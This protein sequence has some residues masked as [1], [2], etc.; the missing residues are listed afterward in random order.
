MQKEVK[1]NISWV[2]ARRIATL[3]FL[4]T[5]MMSIV[6]LIISHI[7]NNINVALISLML[8]F[9]GSIIFAFEKIKY[10]I[11]LLLF[12]ICFFTFL[13]GRIFLLSYEKSNW[14][15]PF[16]ESVMQKS[17]N[18]M[19]IALIFIVIGFIF[20]EI[21]KFRRLKNQTKCI[22][23]LISLQN[24]KQIELFRLVSQIVM[25]ISFVPSFSFLVSTLLYSRRFG[26]ISLYT[27]YVPSAFGNKILVIYMLSFYLFLATMPSKNKVILYS[28]PYFITT[29]VSLLTGDRGTFVTS[30]FILAYYY[31][32][33]HFANKQ[34]FENDE[35]KWINGKIVII[36]VIV[37]PVLLA[38]LIIWGA[39]RADSGI[40]LGEY[41]SFD[42][43]VSIFKEFFKEQG[44]SS[45]IIS[46]A[47]IHIE[48][49]P[50]TNV[51]YSFGRLIE[52]VKHNKITSIVYTSPNPINNRIDYALYA[53]DFAHT[54]SY[55]VKP[56]NYSNGY[57][58]GSSYI[59]ELFVD[60]GL[61]GVALYNLL[62]GIIMSYF[63]VPK[64]RNIF[65][66][67]FFMMSLK[68][69]FLLPRISA[70]EFIHS[71]LNFTNL[72]FVFLVFVLVKTANIFLSG[73]ILK[74]NNIEEITVSNK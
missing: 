54:I 6:L 62:L 38:F 70:S 15:D 69:I 26:Y 11:M 9:I 18:M 8:A 25:I 34:I 60:F 48:D 63:S 20:N 46:Y 65:V 61:F 10:R 55:I 71:S 16:P 29:F 33:R 13:I 14:W 66:H 74:E 2:I 59:A 72:L 17:I 30:I 32:Y 43:I 12:S 21:I 67:A 35:D 3:S 40:N 56:Y 57:G 19:S 68:Y 42:S 23:S 41:L 28:I 53:N 45:E 52:F 44:I 27:T 4:S 37:A 31:I 39:A 51:N 1:V 22:N 24:E 73:R 49:L 58:I 7:Q 64:R 36:S 5:F 50:D 47:Q